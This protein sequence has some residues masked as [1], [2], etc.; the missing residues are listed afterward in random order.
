[1][2]CQNENP[3]H[4]VKGWIS[5]RNC[6]EKDN[7]NNKDLFIVVHAAPEASATNARPGR[8]LEKATLQLQPLQ[9]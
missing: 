1:M 8:L 9:K 2:T 3:E 4:A 6:A 5:A 7:D